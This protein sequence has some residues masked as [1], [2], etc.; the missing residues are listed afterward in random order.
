MSL[1]INL[2]PYTK[3]NSKWVTDLNAKHKIIMIK[4]KKK[5]KIFRILGWTKNHKLETKSTIQKCLERK[6][7][8]IG[9]SK[10]KSF[11]LGKALLRDGKTSYRVGNIFV[12]HISDKGLESRLYKLLSRKTQQTIG[13]MSKSHE[14]TFF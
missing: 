12:N 3:S 5:E 7:W 10:L 14:E 8:S 9:L 13:N 11:V 1:S 6:N 2:S 4:K